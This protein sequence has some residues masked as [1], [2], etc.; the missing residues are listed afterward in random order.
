MRSQILTLLTTTFGFTGIIREWSRG[1]TMGEVATQRSTKSFGEYMPLRRRGIFTSTPATSQAQTTPQMVRRGAYS[2]HSVF[3]SLPSRY[4]RPSK[5]LS[6]TQI[7]N[8]STRTSH[9]ISPQECETRH[10]I[11]RRNSTQAN[12]QTQ[13]SRPSVARINA[14]SDTPRRRAL[15]P[16]RVVL[17]RIGEEEPFCILRP[18]CPTADRLLHWRPSIPSNI[19]PPSLTDED[20]ARVSLAAVRGYNVSTRA[21]YGAGIKLFMEVCDVKEIPDRDR[22]PASRD[23]VAVFLSQLVGAYSASAAK[24]YYAALRA[25][26]IIHRMAWPDDKLQFHNLLH[27]ATA[28]APAMSRQSPKQPY[29]VQTLEKV[30]AEL[31]REVPLDAAVAAT[32]NVLFWGLGRLGE[33]TV[34]TQ[35]DFDAAHHVQIKHWREEADR[36]GREVWTLFIPRTKVAPRGE[37]IQW[38]RQEGLSDPVEAFRNHVEVNNPRAGEHL[39]SYTITYRSGGSRRVPLTRSAFLNRLKAAASQ[40][41]VR[42]L[43]GHAFR[44]GGT[45][46]YL[47]RGVPF[48]VVKTHGRWRGDAFQLYLRKHAQILAPYLQANPEAHVRFVNVVMPRVR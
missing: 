3:S 14:G 25:W 33:L 27:A 12:R 24:N 43:T 45:L 15:R 9:R 36:E 44:I 13:N 34:K 26:H 5:G 17:E 8:P 31:D 28:E 2:P 20:R 38:A 40:A 23:L 1:G 30:L 21:T 6:S 48:E 10:P 22:V 35:K 39:M 19:H 42:N 11:R 46:E 41:E 4:R 47:L 29:T 18:N 16:R 37:P 7:L 32:A